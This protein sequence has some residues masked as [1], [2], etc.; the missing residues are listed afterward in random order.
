M[1]R[2]NYCGRFIGYRTRWHYTPYGTV[3]DYEPPDDVNICVRC[4]DALT[5][6]DIALIERIAWLPLVKFEIENEKSK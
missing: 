2:C 1:I 5:E 3:L 4:H 6:E